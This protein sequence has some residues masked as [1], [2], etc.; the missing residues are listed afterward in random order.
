MLSVPQGKEGSPQ[1]RK[2]LSSRCCFYE[3]GVLLAKTVMFSTKTSF[4]FQN[5]F[6]HLFRSR[7]VTR[8]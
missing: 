7:C 5:T 1:N 2:S 3:W 8:I 6:Y 4:P